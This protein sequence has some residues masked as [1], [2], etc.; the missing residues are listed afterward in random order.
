[1]QYEKSSQKILGQTLMIVG[2]LPL[3]EHKQVVFCARESWFSALGPRQSTFGFS[4]TKQP[5]SQIRFLFLVVFEVGVAPSHWVR[6][7]TNSRSGISCLY[8]RSVGERKCPLGSRI[9]GHQATES[10]Q[11]TPVEARPGQNRFVPE[12]HVPRKSKS[13]I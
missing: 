10:A 13:S 7:W 1:M 4:S 11:R 2:I 9:R 6:P 12:I 3:Q 8:P 5:Q